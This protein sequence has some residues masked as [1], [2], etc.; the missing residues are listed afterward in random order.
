MSV[1]NS[2]NIKTTNFQHSGSQ[3]AYRGKKK[4]EAAFQ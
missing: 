1:N 4:E 3:F 2:E